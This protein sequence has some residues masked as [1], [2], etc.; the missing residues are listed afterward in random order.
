MDAE[1]AKKGM[2][3]LIEDECSAGFP[4]V[5]RIPSTHVWKA[6]AHIEAIDAQERHALF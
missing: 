4:F 2:R 5:R 1:S 3:R 6:L